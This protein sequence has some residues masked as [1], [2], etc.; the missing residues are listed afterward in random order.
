MPQGVLG[1]YWSPDS[2]YVAFMSGGIS[3]VIVNTEI[4]EAFTFCFHNRRETAGLDPFLWSPDSSQFLLQ[5]EDKS[6]IIVDVTDNQA[7]EISNRTDLTAI[8][9]LS[10]YN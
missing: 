9:W 5:F 3:P 7:Y 6:S 10:Q 4:Q 2:R 8:G 1:I